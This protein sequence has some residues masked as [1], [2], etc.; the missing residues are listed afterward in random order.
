M[1][2]F[3]KIKNIKEYLAQLKEKR[4]E[5]AFVPTMGF[6]HEGHLSLIDKARNEAK[7]VV[8]SIF[9]NRMQFN[10]REDFDNYPINLD[11]DIRKLRN[12]GVDILFCPDEN[13][14]DLQNNVIDFNIGELQYNLCGK[15]RAHHFDGVVQIVNRLF[16]IINPD[17]AIFGEKDFQQLQIIRYFIKKSSI[18]LKILSSPILRESNGLAMSSRNSRLSNKSLQNAV[19]IFKS[20]TLIKKYLLSLDKKINI[21]DFLQK[22]KKELEEAFEKVEYLKI[23]TET[24]L[25]DIKILNKGQ[26]S[27]IFIAV[28][29]DG[30]RLIDNIKLF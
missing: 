28:Y 24:D 25:R 14:I 1:I 21:D 23:C 16:K 2:I 30:V 5:V 3:K 20:L 17:I 8:V 26:D 22:K 9:V 12:K 13:E 19:K 18:S 15:Y 27:R 29:V 7:I 6:L 10:N 4:G 11:L